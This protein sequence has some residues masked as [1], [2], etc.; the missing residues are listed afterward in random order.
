MDDINQRQNYTLLTMV[1]CDSLHIRCE[2]I[3]AVIC[4]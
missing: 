4:L 1:R 3:V 2:D